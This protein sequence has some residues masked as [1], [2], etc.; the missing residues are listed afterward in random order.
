MS[1]KAVSKELQNQNIFKI[2]KYQIDSVVFV[3]K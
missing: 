1:S 3:E 2:Y